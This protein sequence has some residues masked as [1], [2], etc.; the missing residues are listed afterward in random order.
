MMPSTILLRHGADAHVEHPFEQNNG[1]K[2]GFG[3]K[4]QGGCTALAERS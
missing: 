2:N 4:E 3:W 1:E